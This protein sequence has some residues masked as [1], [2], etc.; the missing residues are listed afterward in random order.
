MAEVLARGPGHA[1]LLAGPEG[2]GKRDFAREFAA[3]LVTPCG[4]CGECADCERARRGAHPD[5]V[6]IEREGE[7]IRIEQVARL[8]ADLSLKPFSAERRVWVIIEPERM[9][10]EAANK[11]LKSLEEPPAHVHF[12]LVSDAPERV[13]PTVLS[14]CQRID[15]GPVA[16]HEL[17]E[18]L[19]AREGL[20]PQAALAL[21]RLA[22][23]SI[24]RARRLAEDARGD[25]RRDRYLRLAARVAMHDRDAERAFVDEVERAGQAVSAAVAADIEARRAELERS[26]FDKQELAWHTRRL[27]GLARREEARRARLSYLDAV[28]HLASWLH[29]AWAVGLGAPQAAW[30]SDRLAELEHASVARPDLYA[31]LIAVA[32]ATRKDLSLNVD[33]GLAL[34]A[35]FA[36]FQEVWESA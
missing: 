22:R 8:I 9:N 7:F 1:Y 32:D 6:V 33:R 15:F 13:L 25:G 2:L 20:P 26:V 27:D 18:A 12:V 17:A 31:G 36:R 30:N 3:A 21:A 4:G 34:R 10:V 35:M 23:G 28:D 19:E 16:D 24:G 29:D 5:L 14:R 11:F